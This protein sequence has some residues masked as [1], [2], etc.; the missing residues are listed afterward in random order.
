MV[1]SSYKKQRILFLRAKGYRAPTIAKLLR[2]E[3]L[4]CS[5]VGVAKFMRKFKQTGTI[6]RHIGSGRPSKVTAEIKQLVEDQ[7]RLNDE[8]TAVQ[9]HRLLQ[10]KGY[11]VS[12]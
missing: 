8:T 10:D 4:Q 3:K 12:L 6:S 7:M 5:R 11:N 9:L 2:D 1:F